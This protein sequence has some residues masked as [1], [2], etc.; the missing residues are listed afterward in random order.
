MAALGWPSYCIQSSPFLFL[1]LPVDMAMEINPLCDPPPSPV[2]QYR[3]FIACQD[4]YNSSATHLVE[5][6][7]SRHVI[8]SSA[9]VE[10][11]R[12]LDSNFN[13]VNTLFGVHRPNESTTYIRSGCDRVVHSRLWWQPSID[14]T[15][16][17]I[18]GN[19][20]K[21]TYR[22]RQQRK[23]IYQVLNDGC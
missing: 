14:I 16:F 20:A 13:R 22:F 12:L 10:S 23:N 4:P 18:D 5:T 9:Q 1:L 3:S 19:C 11:W 15:L 21:T 2:S 6:P 7:A 8:C 17:S